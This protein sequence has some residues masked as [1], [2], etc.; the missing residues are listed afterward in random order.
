MKTS[1]QRKC[2]LLRLSDNTVIRV[3]KDF[4]ESLCDVYQL[5]DELSGLDEVVCTE[6][7]ATVISNTR[8]TEKI[9]RYK[10]TGYER[11]RFRT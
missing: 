10:A 4:D 8:P 2:T 7:L 3:D 1:K 6:R 9:F 11:P 5:R